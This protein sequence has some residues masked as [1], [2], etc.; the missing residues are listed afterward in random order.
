MSSRTDQTA[1]PAQTSAAEARIAGTISKARLALGFER[2]WAAL[3]WPLLMGMVAVALVVSGLLLRLHPWPRAAVLAILVFA[4]FWSL[5]DV[6]RVRWPTR[7]DAMRRV[8]EKSGLSHRP[9]SAREDRLAEE[10]AGPL[11]K[12]I[13]EEHRQRQLQGLERLKAGL[14][15][16]RWRDIDPR[17]LRLPAAL[18]LVAALLLGP[19]D[20]RSNLADSLFFMASPPAAQMALDAWL[21]PPAYTAKPPL[22]PTSP[23]MTER[24]KTE[25]DIHVPEKSTLSLRI[26][27]AKAPVLSFHELMDTAGTA[28]L[29]AG[30]APRTKMA[31]GLFQAE[32]TL[33]RPALVKVSDQGKELASW[34]ISLIPDAPPSIEITD[35][36]S[37]DSSGT[38][39]ARWKAG[40]DYG[41]T[42]ITSDIYLAD[43][44]DEGVGFSDPGIFEFDPPKLPINLRKAS[45]LEE[46]GESK[47]DV[48][49]HPWASFMVE[50]R[51]TA[52]DAAGNRTEST[53]RVFRMPERLFTKPLARALVEQRRQLILAPEE[54][55][56]VAEMLEALLTYPEGLIERSGTHIA[57]AATLSRLRAAEDRAGIDSVIR[58]LWQIAVNVEDGSF[59]DA[60]AELEAL[61]KELE[62][63]LRDGASPERIAELTQKLREAL[64]RY[65]QSMMEEA[66]KRRAQGEQ[67]QQAQQNQQQG[68]TVT[69]QDLQRMLDTIEKLAQSGAKDAAEQMLSELENILR[70]LQ[71]G[72]PQEGQIQDGPM[73]EMLDSLSDLMRQQQKL[74]DD[75]QRMPQDGMG[76]DPQPGQQQGGMGDLGERQQNLGR[77]LQELMDQFGRNGMQTPRAFGEAGKSMQGAEGSIREGDR[78]QALDNQGDAM[79]KLREG[80]QGLARQMMQQSQGEQ[81]SPGRNGEARGDDRDP[82]G[83]PM[84][85]SGEDYGPQRDMLP[86]ELAIQRAREILDM[87]R[88]RAGEQGLPAIERDY[89]ERLLRGLY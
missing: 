74:M 71:P 16:S 25:A 1:T 38:L 88:A 60:K 58:M 7:Q 57:I 72:M 20:T 70:N 66:R 89:I 27:G 18:A 53:K 86:S 62:R 12:A 4:L 11:Q 9:V 24:L 15:Q 50:M 82:L 32:V 75:T 21:K 3:H 35:D 14:P 29:V 46:A 63:A 39:T 45:P 2:V 5:R 13:W 42:G 73:N 78:D 68:S 30:F 34:R 80:A 76:Q 85:N 41:V 47:T 31:D 8:E 49:E 67:N 26:S 54:A 10:S 44:Q 19:G 6:I 28:P 55:G 52:R 69:P 23:P 64:D 48:A 33:A 43:E 81:A 22:L 17:A 56:G 61:R 36:P 40:D 51:L 77:M 83:R 87:L 65:M 59:A 84:P 37:G 79:A